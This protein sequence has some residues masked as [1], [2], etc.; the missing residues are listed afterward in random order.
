MCRYLSALVSVQDATGVWARRRSGSNLARQ[1]R[2]PES[3]RPE[4]NRMT[5]RVTSRTIP[6]FFSDDEGQDLIE[7][8]LLAGLISLVAVTIILNLG[9]SVNGVWTGLD[10]S[11]GSIPSP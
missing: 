11:M 6:N 5:I 9:T 4:E 1:V 3:M 8:S 7:Y 2:Q 10:S